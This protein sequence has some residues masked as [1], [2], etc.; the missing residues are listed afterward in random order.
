MNEEIDSVHMCLLS[1]DKQKVLESEQ[2]HLLSTRKNRGS[3][4]SINM[5]QWRKSVKNDLRNFFR[6]PH[7]TNYNFDTKGF[8]GHAEMPSHCSHY[9]C[10]QLITAPSNLGWRTEVVSIPYLPVF[11]YL[12]CIIGVWLPMPLKKLIVTGSI[13][14]MIDP[15][16]T[17]NVCNS[18]C[19]N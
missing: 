9:N 3:Q 6:L 18:A 4:R 10:G 16:C 5:A 7:Q 1:N 11:L 12:E 8:Y 14:Y 15:C 17:Q 13:F 19:E 2:T